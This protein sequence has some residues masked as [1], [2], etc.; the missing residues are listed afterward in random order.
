MNTCNSYDL[1]LSIFFFIIISKKKKK[2][3]FFRPAT[4][5]KILCY[6]ITLVEVVACVVSLLAQTKSDL[7][8]NVLL[9]NKKGKNKQ[10]SHSCTGEV[11]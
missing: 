6:D 9:K 8:D 10:T 3:S 5:V 1:P 4:K 11:F 7:K 2:K